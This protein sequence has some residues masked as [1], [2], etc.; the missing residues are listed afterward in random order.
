MLTPI[1]FIITEISAGFMEQADK[2]Q[3]PYAS[4][5]GVQAYPNND[6]RTNGFSYGSPTLKIKLIDE[7]TGN[8]NHKLADELRK[9]NVFLQELVLN[10]RTKLTKAGMQFECLSVEFP[11]Q[12]KKA[13]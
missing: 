10:C 8:P 5:T 9:S 11:Q 6:Q 13:G 3:T 12:A 4:V 7:A 2:S 1:N